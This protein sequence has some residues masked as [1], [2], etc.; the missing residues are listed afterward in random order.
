[1]F[2]ARPRIL[3]ICHVSAAEV[4]AEA[5]RAMDAEGTISN[6]PEPVLSEAIQPRI[7]ILCYGRAPEDRT[8]PAGTRFVGPTVQ[9]GVSRFEGL[10]VLA[11]LRKRRYDVVALSQ[12][13]LGLS[14]AR[15]VLV[16]FSR[17]ISGRHVVILDPGAKRVVRPISRGLAVEELFR[18]LSLNL[19]AQIV[20][21]GAV[22]VLKRLTSDIPAL[23]VPTTGQ[24]VYL[25]TDIELSVQPLSAGGSVAHTEGILEALLER[26]HQVAY[27]GT[28]EVDG[29]PATIP[30]R[31]LPAHMKG[32]LA[33]ELAEFLS[34]I[35]QGSIRV[36][37]RGVTGCSSKAAFIYQR[38]SLNN[39][40]GVILARRWR[41]PLVLEAN[42]S[43]AKWRQ[44]FGTLT[45]PGLAYACERFILRRADLIT[46]VSA[47][48]AEDLLAAG[49]PAGR[50]RVVPNG[51]RVQR[52]AE[53]EPI[54]LPDGIRG[55]FVVCFVGLF[56]P[57]H[58][59]RFLAEAFALMHL[60]H[61]D[62]RL[63]LVGDG[64]ETPAV[65]AVLERQTALGATHF[66]GLVPRADAPRYMAAADVLVSPHADVDHF[67]G[68]P[69]KL[70]EYMAAGKPIV[71][72]RVG[73]IPEILTDGRTALLVPPERPEAMAAAL[74]R[75]YVDR[76][77][78]KKLGKAAR[79]EA[80]LQ[81]SWD[82]RLASALDTGTPPRRD[83]MAVRC[84]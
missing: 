32:N 34:G 5:A 35:L 45:Y 40:A 84:R 20:A 30:K 39:L 49:A 29:I 26:G 24:V 11:S 59:V 36:E 27:W 57:W 78:G 55:S 60:H 33:T 77:L 15:G 12:P 79:L 58:G 80:E 64:E 18:W 65:R 4:A 37:R 19:A 16:V 3:V 73:Q 14:R 23:E 66:T 82:A 2:E 72:T 70:F 53:A 31:R 9:Q 76:A 13:F 43:E 22:P 68:S 61:P 75:L 50:V 74:E 8:A 28:G 47:N 25:R 69:I 48:A 41:V 6:H 52:F 10:R 46:A 63:L 83:E 42:G 81:H 71:A 54:R 38:Y 7:D 51:V 21:S 67:I 1:V 56:Y 44:D 17:L 62:V